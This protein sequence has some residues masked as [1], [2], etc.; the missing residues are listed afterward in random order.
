[1]R[2]GGGGGRLL[3]G[4]VEDEEA[5]GAEGLRVEAED[6]RGAEA[7]EEP[8]VPDV[9]KEPPIVRPAVAAHGGG[10]GWGEV[11]RCELKE[12]TF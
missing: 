4:A 5:G 9:V 8:P 2:R 6:A 1:M 3:R 12:S 10:R 7:S 11:H